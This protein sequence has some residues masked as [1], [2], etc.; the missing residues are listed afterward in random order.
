MTCYND[1]TAPLPPHPPRPPHRPI[2]EESNGAREGGEGGGAMM[3]SQWWRTR[4]HAFGDGGGVDEVAAAQRTR[5]IGVQLTERQQTPAAAIFRS[6]G[7]GVG[8][9][10]VLHSA[11]AL[12]PHLRHYQHRFIQL[13]LNNQ[14]RQSY[15]NQGIVQLLC[16]QRNRDVVKICKWDI[17]L[18]FFLN[19]N[20]SPQLWGRSLDT[21][22][23]PLRPTA[24]TSLPSMTS[25]AGKR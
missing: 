19:W 23:W 10:V 13:Q 21:S 8:G 18:V 3:T 6:G 14:W 24:V 15:A 20:K 17:R 22:S 5:Q 12:I 4:V 2:K 16:F 7:G 1:V 25:L 9:V 11:A